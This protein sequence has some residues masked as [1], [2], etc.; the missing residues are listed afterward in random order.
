MSDQLHRFVFEDSAVRGECVRLA[1]TWQAV[2]ERH[3]YPPPLRLLLGELMAAGALLAATLKFD[4]LLSLQLQGSGPV[5]L[6]VVECTRDQGMRAT[7]KWQGDIAGDGLRQLLGDGRFV[8]N[9]M[10]ADGQPGYQGVVGLEGDSVASALEH[11]MAASEQIPTRLWLA[12]DDRHAAGLLIQKLP[13]R[14]DEDAD[15]WPRAGHLAATVSAPELLGLDAP[16]LLRRLF[17][18]EDLRLF[19]AKPVCFRCTCTRERVAGMLRMLGRAE[20]DDLIA[21]RGEV[22]VHCEFC[23]RRYAF[24]A[25]DSAQLFA[26]NGSGGPG[27][28]RH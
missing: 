2:I 17:H 23:N 11:Y 24:D 25:V 15:T 3:D 6:I 18:K 21:R 19:E 28:T 14:K 8:V 10:P 1:A 12:C 13:E 5:K 22:E 4:G 16:A 27:G 7:A 9:L 26:G 20:V